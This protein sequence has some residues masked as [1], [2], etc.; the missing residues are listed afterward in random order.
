MDGAT[1]HKLL[2][3][4]RAAQAPAGAGP[5]PPPPQVPSP[6]T[7]EGVAEERSIAGRKTMKGGEKWDT[8]TGKESAREGPAKAVETEEEHE[9]EV[10]L[11]S[12][13]KKGP[14]KSLPWPLHVLRRSEN[15]PPSNLNPLMPQSL[16]F[17][18]PIVRT[19][20]RRKISCS[21]NTPSRRRPL[22]L[23]ST[24]IPSV[25]AY[26]TSWRRAQADARC[27]MFSL[28]AKVSAAVMTSRR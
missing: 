21:P 25:R 19:P 14:S 13:L 20:E 6:T 2:D 11:N 28:T 4:Q 16:S 7:E 8:A 1:Q 9:V 10:E 15:Q 12:I 18:K 3:V 24:S 17:P 22:W 27:R 26:K 5:V 23:S